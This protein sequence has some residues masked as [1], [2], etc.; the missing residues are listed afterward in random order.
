MFSSQ[1]QLIHLIILPPAEHTRVHWPVATMASLQSSMPPANVNGELILEEHNWK[2]DRQALSIKVEIF[3]LPGIQNQ[4][5][6]LPLPGLIR[7]CM[8]EVDM[9]VI[10][11]I[12]IRP[13]T[14]SGERIMVELLMIMADLSLPIET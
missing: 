6:E 12:S 7:Q 4:L 14:G 13:V 8:A 5:P 1:E 3:M 9:I 11:K 2:T 10:L